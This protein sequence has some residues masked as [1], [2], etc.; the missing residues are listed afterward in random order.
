M[1]LEN[2]NQHADD[3][4]V[5][6][7]SEAESGELVTPPHGDKLPDLADAA[8]SR[9]DDPGDQDIDTTGTEADP[10]FPKTQT[11]EPTSF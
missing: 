7:P 2:R 5:A 10:D 6:N 1:P 4:N 9:D 11:N 3:P 8:I